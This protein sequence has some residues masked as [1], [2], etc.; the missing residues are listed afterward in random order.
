MSAVGA[1]EEESC[2]YYSEGDGDE[3]DPDVDYFTFKVF[4]YCL[5]TL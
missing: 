5:I 1:N 3:Y 2:E 4:Y